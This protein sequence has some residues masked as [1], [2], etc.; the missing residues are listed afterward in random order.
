M[1]VSN[2]DGKAVGAEKQ[3]LL[4]AL[5]YLCDQAISSGSQAKPTRNAVASPAA[6]VSFKRAYRLQNQD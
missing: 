2:P 1:N 3:H 5:L 6:G 4:L